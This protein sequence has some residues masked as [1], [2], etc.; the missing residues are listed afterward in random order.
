MAARI[1]IEEWVTIGEGPIININ[2]FV[3]TIKP[4]YT[5]TSDGLCNPKPGRFNYSHLRG[6]VV[7][8]E[9]GALPTNTLTYENPPCFH[10]LSTKKIH[11][12]N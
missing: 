1:V 10:K 9:T 4:Q 2:S 3:S 7:S 5:I 6:Y 12:T 8:I 11:E